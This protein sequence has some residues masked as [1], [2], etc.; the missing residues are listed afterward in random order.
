MMGGL[1]PKA[2]P[3]HM[4]VFCMTHQRPETLAAW[5]DERAGERARRK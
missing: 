2:A 3:K 5:A 4:L 1:D